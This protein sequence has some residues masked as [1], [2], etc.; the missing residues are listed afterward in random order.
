MVDWIAHVLACTWLL[1]AATTHAQAPEAQLPALG[2][3]AP[4]EQGERA[5][6]A[7][8]LVRDADLFGLQTGLMQCR[9]SLSSGERLHAQLLEAR[10]EQERARTLAA[11]QSAELHERL[12]TQRAEQLAADLA[13]ARASNSQWWSSPALWFALGVIVTGAAAVALAMAVGR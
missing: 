5:P 2:E 4:L 9:Y 6:W 7:G 8:M 3:T 1:Y 13:A 10:L 12:W 11:T